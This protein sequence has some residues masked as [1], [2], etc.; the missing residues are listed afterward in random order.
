[1][2]AVQIYTKET[3]PL[4]NKKKHAKLGT[5]ELAKVFSVSSSQ[6]FLFCKCK[7]ETKSR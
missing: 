3:G 7:Q 5:F 6:K 1:M 2:T 4:Q